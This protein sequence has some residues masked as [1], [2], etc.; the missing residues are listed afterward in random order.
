[1][2]IIIMKVT[3]TRLNTCYSGGGLNIRTLTSNSGWS[4]DGWQF[5]LL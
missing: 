1:M 4:I 3:N 5:L 2:N